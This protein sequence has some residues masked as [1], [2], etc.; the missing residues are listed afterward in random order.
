[1][2]K[3]TYK[4]IIGI[5]RELGRSTCLGAI[6]AA[7][8]TSITLSDPTGFS[9][10]SKVT[11]YDGALTEVV[12]ASALVGSVLTVGATANAHLTP[13]VLI[14]T[15]GTV[16]AVPTDYIPVTKFDASDNQAFAEDKGWRGSLVDVYDLVATNRNATLDIG[17]DVFADTFGYFLGGVLGDV[18]FAAASPNTHTF[19][20]LNSGTGQPPSFQITDFYSAATRQYGGVQFSD[21]NI[22]GSGE[23][24][25]T[26]DCKATAY[27]SGTV[28]T[29]TASFGTIRATPGYAGVTTLN[30]TVIDKL[31]SV[32]LSIKRSV[33]IVSNIDGGP[34]PFKVWDGVV[35]VGGKATYVVDDDTFLN[36]YLNNTQ[37]PLS[38]AWNI[39][40]G[41]SQ[42][43]LTVT[44]TKAAHKTA[45]LN[46]GKSYVAV[47]ADIAAIANT[48]DAGASAGYSPVKVVLR[49]A[50]AT[51]TYG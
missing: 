27:A 34:D 9:A 18:V 1:M 43:G 19:S 49:N 32:D 47:D 12:T 4:S 37:P 29:P 26:Y 8:A 46:R 28:A 35:S 6:G 42:V 30:G 23:G 51:G 2:P 11:I 14:T 5:A 15:T 3:S 17:G 39:G 21:L 45:K 31:V 48:T 38:I 50:K 41:A 44:M 25:L 24:L 22:K 10:T 13:G 20:V 36:Y 40:T 33:D 7:G 16:S